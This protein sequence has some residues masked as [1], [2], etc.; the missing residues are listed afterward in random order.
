MSRTRK[1]VAAQLGPVHLDTPR[2]EILN[3]LIE[4]LRSA[5]LQGTTLVVFPELAFT[6]FFAQHLF[7]SPTCLDTFFEHDTDISGASPTKRLFEEALRLCVDICVGYA[8][9]TPEGRAFNSAIY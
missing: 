6:T 2:E 4:L 8:E 3:R 9:K 1:V 5:A 7:D